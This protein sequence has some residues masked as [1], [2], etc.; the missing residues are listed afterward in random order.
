MELWII[1][2]IIAAT[3]RPS[4][5]GA[6]KMKSAMGDFGASYIRFS[7][8]LPFAALWLWLWMQSTEQSL[9]QT[10]QMFWVWVSIGGLMQ[11]ISQ[12]F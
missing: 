6:K 10:T 9:P 12:F 1:I 4:V 5:G 7:Y 11:V 3:T 2:T 8:A